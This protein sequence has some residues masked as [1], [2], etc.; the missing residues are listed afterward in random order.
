MKDK[1][2]I[3]LLIIIFT[4]ILVSMAVSGI[5]GAKIRNAMDKRRVDLLYSAWCKD[6][7]N[8]RNLTEEEFKVYKLKR[9]WTGVWQ[10][11]RK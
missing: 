7:G 9:D 6:T 1:I 5:R 10:I 8:I 4:S 3:V 2:G 11:R